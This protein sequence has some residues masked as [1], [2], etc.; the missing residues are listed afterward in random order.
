MALP[1]HFAKLVTRVG[2]LS[3]AGLVIVALAHGDGDFCKASSPITIDRSDRVTIQRITFSGPW[4][5]NDATVFLPN[6]REVADGGVVFSHSSIHS[7]KGVTDMVPFALTLSQAGAGVIVLDRSITWPSTA[8]NMNREGDAVF[9]ATQWFVVNVRVFN[10]TG[11]IRPADGIGR[12]MPFAYVGPR[13]CDPRVS[14]GCTLTSPFNKA[15]Y[16]LAVWVP[17]AETEGGDNTKGIISDGGLRS[18]QWIQ[19]SLGLSPIAALI[20]GPPGSRE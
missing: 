4:G 13:I 14:S 15:P 17:V 5:S 7:A 20:G 2:L 9:C 19:R 3:I 11:T 8:S 1:R 16:H 6:D 12:R 18:A 10:A